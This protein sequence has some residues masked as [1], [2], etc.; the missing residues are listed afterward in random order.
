MNR[1]IREAIKAKQFPNNIKQEERLFLT[2]LQAPHTIPETKK[3]VGVL[4]KQ[5]NYTCPRQNFHMLN[6]Q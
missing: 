4:Q 2:V 3:T 6:K 5:N 1:L